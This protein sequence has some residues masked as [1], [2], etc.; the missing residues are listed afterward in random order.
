[1]TPTAKLNVCVMPL[2]NYRRHRATER[3]LRNGTG[4]FFRSGLCEL[5]QS[6]MTDTQRLKTGF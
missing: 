1:M 6:L 5:L 4:T 2:I 3:H